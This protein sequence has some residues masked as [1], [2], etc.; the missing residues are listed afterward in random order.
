[1]PLPKHEIDEFPQLLIATLDRAAT[2]LC[3]TRA[4]LDQ[5]VRALRMVRT[6]ER[7]V[8][9]ELARLAWGNP[10]LRHGLI[11][12]AGQALAGRIRAREFEHGPI[13]YGQPQPQP[14][15]ESLS[16]TPDEPPAEE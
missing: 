10:Y 4:D 2:K 3:Y 6:A 9:K 5:V 7:I 15:A 13:A 8:V 16:S 14:K 1:M 11:E 12:L